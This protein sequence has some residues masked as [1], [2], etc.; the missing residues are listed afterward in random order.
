[1]QL[2]DAITTR[3]SAT[4]LSEPGPTREQLQLILD[5]GSRA[6]DHGRLSPW[7]FVVLHGAARQILSDAMV[8]MLRERDPTISTTALDAERKKAW[9]A[10][11]IVVVA[12]GVQR[13]AKVP[14]IEQVLAVA[15]SVQNM[16]LTAHDLGLG[17]MWKTGPAA[18]SAY[19]KSTLG[20]A[21]SDHIVAF[22]YLGTSAG[23]GTPR[24]ADADRFTRWL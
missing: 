4:R 3:A 17:A 14:E 19:V 2:R 6:P 18:Y 15:A 11:T 22:L 16:F 24:A 8:Q 23:Q 5:A 1:M 7:R 13:H 9:R 20:L 10:P 21:T 12:A